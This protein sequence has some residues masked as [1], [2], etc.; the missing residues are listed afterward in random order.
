MDFV[1]K[2]FR[3]STIRAHPTKPGYTLIEQTGGVEVNNNVP[4]ALRG[5]IENFACG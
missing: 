5:P 1:G 3:T 4:A 2:A